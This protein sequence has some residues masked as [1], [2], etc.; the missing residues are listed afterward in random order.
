MTLLHAGNEW[1]VGSLAT[2]MEAFL[3]AFHRAMGFTFMLHNT[4]FRN[5]MVS[6][7]MHSMILIVKGEVIGFIL[8]VL[9]ELKCG[10][11]SGCRWLYKMS[12]IKLLWLPE[13]PPLGHFVW[14]SNSSTN[15]RFNEKC[16]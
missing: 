13:M 2:T 10:H 3:S 11:S 5:S 12:V 15:Q 4:V 9:R 6:F 16:L 7:K 14:H 8:L 1:V